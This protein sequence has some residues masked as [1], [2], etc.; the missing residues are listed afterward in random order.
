M[1]EWS[2][3]LVFVAVPIAAILLGALCWWIATQRRE[4]PE[5]REKALVQ[6]R[7]LRGL[8]VSPGVFEWYGEPEVYIPHVRVIVPDHINELVLETYNA[9]HFRWFYKDSTSDV[10]KVVRFVKKVLARQQ[11][12]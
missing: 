4:P 3:S 9:P 5:W 6:F 7:K 11:D 12:V 10:V 1:S 2:P 8:E